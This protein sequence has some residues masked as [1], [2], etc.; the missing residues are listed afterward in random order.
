MKI[1]NLNHVE[2]ATQEIIG[3]YRGR[4][5][6]YRPVYVN[7]ANAHAGAAAFGRNTATFTS[8][9]TLAVSGFSSLSGS[10]SSS[11]TIG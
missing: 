9:G 2:V 3:G 10:S 11:T 7:T 4:Y 6:Y 5:Y 8:T 1:N